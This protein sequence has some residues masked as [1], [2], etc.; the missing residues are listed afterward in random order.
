MNYLTKDLLELKKRQKD[1]E[2]SDPSQAKTINNNLFVGS[3]A[4]L[5]QFLKRQNE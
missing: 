3:T 4:E 2:A 1:I 5:Q